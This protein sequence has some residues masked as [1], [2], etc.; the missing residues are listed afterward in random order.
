MIL[1][2][3]NSAKATDCASTIELAMQETVHVVSNLH[4]ACDR[5]QSVE[6]AA[7]LVDQWISDAEPLLAGTFFD[8]LG[9]AVPIFVNFAISSERRVLR[10]LQAAL[11]RRTLEV[12]RAREYTRQALRDEFKDDVTALLLSCEMG[13]EEEQLNQLARARFQQIQELAQ[14]M[15]A[16]LT[17]EVREESSEQKSAAATA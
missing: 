5:L 6:Y 17:T 13:V 15:K 2:V 16:K 12:E 10:E 14:R 1:L 3:W 4:A 7:V 9:R 11:S 8:D